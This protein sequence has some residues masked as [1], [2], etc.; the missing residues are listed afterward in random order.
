MLG[1][2]K[3]PTQPTV[4]P[5]IPAWMPESSHMDVNL[6]AALRLNPVTVV[7]ENYHPWHWIPAS[8]LE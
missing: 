8:M 5:V 3:A 6:W 1:F 2:R 7:S 4:L